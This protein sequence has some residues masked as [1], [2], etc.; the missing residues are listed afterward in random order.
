VKE[1]MGKLMQCNGT[2]DWQT[3]SCSDVK[4]RSELDFADIMDTVGQGL[5]VTGEKW[6]IEYVIL[7]SPEW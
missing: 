7:P 4:A 1:E 6:R 2:R 3:C 5:L